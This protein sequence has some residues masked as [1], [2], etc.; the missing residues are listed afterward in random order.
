MKILL[1]GS[2]GREHSLA[3]KLAA[4]PLVSDLYAL[5]GSDAISQIALCLKGNAAHCDS[6]VATA[7][8]Y[9]ID[10]V[11]IGPEAP[12]VNGVADALRK[13]N[14][15]VFG[16]GADGARLEGS[17]AFTK[18]LCREFDIPTAKSEKFSNREKA[19]KYAATLPLPVVIKA[20]GLAAGKG[21]I[22]AENRADADKAIDDML[23]GAFGQASAEILIEEFLYGEEV[24]VFAITDGKNFL[25]TPAVQDHKRAFDGDKGPN[26][27]G[28]GAYGPAPAYTKN[29]DHDVRDKIIKPTL[30]ALEAHNIKYR[31]VLF[32]GLMLTSD[33]PKLIEYNVRFG[34]PECQILMALLESDL[35]PVLLSAAKGNLASEDDFVFKDLSSLCVVMAAEGYPGSY[36]KESVINGI[37]TA[38]TLPDITVLEAGTN[39]REKQI[40]ASGGRVLNI[41]AV[42]NTLQQAHQKAYEAVDTIQWQGGFCRRDIG[43]RAFHLPK[44]VD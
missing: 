33:G 6:V 4:S 20:D 2:G 30:Q 31:G 35:A 37:D 17:K 40:L 18:E 43:W 29:I 9:Q 28:M 16:P 38:R 39:H 41:V 13:N 22:I 42:A 1:L 44:A 12:L 36:E 21:V 10:L 7:Q 24:S 14:I 3:H 23:G 34:D 5:P 19:K 25:L 26:T 15:A 27:G 32:A 8:K 11:V